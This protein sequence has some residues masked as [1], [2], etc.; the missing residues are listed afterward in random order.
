MLV[1]D[2]YFR[3]NLNFGLNLGSSANYP[4]DCSYNQDKKCEMTFND[5]V[6]H[7]SMLMILLDNLWMNVY[8]FST[9]AS[10]QYYQYSIVSNYGFLNTK[11]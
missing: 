9:N 5:N 3:N 2:E 8:A 6:Y 1:D 7:T 4:T 10:F 11:I